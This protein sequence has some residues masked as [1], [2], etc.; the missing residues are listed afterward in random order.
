M[1]GRFIQIGRHGVASPKRFSAEDKY[2]RYQPLLQFGG[3]HNN[4]G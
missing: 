3:W 2:D 1:F 4:A